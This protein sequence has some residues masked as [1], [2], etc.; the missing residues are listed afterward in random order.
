M[1][2][3]ALSGM[4][5]AC[6]SIVLEVLEKWKNQYLKANKTSMVVHPTILNIGGFFYDKNVFDKIFCFLDNIKK[7][8]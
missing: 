5:I 6:G 4:G 7:S 1:L 3:V 2:A 8:V